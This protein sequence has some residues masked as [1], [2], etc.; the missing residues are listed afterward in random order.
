MAI[1]TSNAIKEKTLLPGHDEIKN[2][3]NINAV[4]CPTFIANDLL[5]YYVFADRKRVYRDE[6]EAEVLILAPEF[7]TKEVYQTYDDKVKRLAKESDSSITWIH[8]LNYQ[9]K[10]QNLSS[11]RNLNTLKNGKN[12][13]KYSE[14]LTIGYTPILKGTPQIAARLT[15]LHNYFKSNL[16]IYKTECMSPAT[17]LMMEFIKINA[18]KAIA[19]TTSGAG[20][21]PTVL[22]SL[23]DRVKYFNGNLANCLNSSPDPTAK[24]TVNES[25]NEEEVVANKLLTDWSYLQAWPS[26]YDFIA[27]PTTQAVTLVEP[28]IDVYVDYLLT[29]NWCK[30]LI[31]NDLL[32]S[33]DEVMAVVAIKDSLTKNKVKFRCLSAEKVNYVHKK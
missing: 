24:K 13:Y 16:N 8:L 23:L 31:A 25:L 10:L 11:M 32:D 21:K 18:R 19:G 22:K 5:A 14:F 17:N 2:M 29:F 28:S 7:D 4:G 27:T 9:T 33:Q 30:N 6:I 20:N 1:K 26:N 12:R 15:S 3:T